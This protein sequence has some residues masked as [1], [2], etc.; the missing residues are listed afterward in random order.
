M[1]VSSSK[2]SSSAWKMLSSYWFLRIVLKLRSSVPVG[3]ETHE[4]LS[5][6]CS[7]G[8][9]PVHWGIGYVS[10]RMRYEVPCFFIAEKSRSRKEPP[11]AIGAREP[12][13]EGRSRASPPDE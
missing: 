12:E 5:T 8:P 11:S 2:R 10:G 3:T 6:S 7:S 9:R 1:A 13:G 4:S